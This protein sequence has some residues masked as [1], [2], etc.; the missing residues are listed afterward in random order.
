MHMYVCVCV[1]LLCSAGFFIET[2][3]KALLGLIIPEDSPPST[4]HLPNI[5]YLAE[6]LLKQNILIACMNLTLYFLHPLKAKL[7]K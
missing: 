6:A 5:V 2:H 4:F 3:T 1:S 7:P